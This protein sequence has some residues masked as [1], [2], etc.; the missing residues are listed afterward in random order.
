MGHSRNLEDP[1]LLEFLVVL[2]I[3]GI[4]RS[5]CLF[6]YYFIVKYSVLKFVHTQFACSVQCIGSKLKES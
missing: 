4:S 3:P 2:Q 6:S 1:T 5:H